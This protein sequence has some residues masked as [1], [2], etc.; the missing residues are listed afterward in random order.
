VIENAKPQS[1]S[2]TS[3]GF[4]L[5]VKKAEQLTKPP[6]RIRGVLVLDRKR[7]YAID[8]RVGAK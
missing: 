7:A 8:F 5:A 1:F 3:F 4:T 2:A 6:T